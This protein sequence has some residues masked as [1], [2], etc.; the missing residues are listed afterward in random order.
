MLQ[1]FWYIMSKWGTI[2]FWWKHVKFEKKEWNVLKKIPIS[3]NFCDLPKL[4]FVIYMN[5]ISDKKC[6][7]KCYHK[8]YRHSTFKIIMNHVTGR[9]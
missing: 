2:T 3:V 9:H 5:K 8:T 4:H 1:K 6:T 7:I